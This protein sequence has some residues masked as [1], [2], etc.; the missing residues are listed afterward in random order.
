MKKIYS[1]ALNKKD[2]AWWFIPEL[3]CPIMLEL[4]KELNRRLIKNEGIYETDLSSSIQLLIDHQLNHFDSLKKKNRR[5]FK[6]TQKDTYDRKAEKFERDYGLL[7]AVDVRTILD[8]FVAYFTYVHPNWENVKGSHK[9]KYYKFKALSKSIANYRVPFA[10]A[11]IIIERLIDS[12]TLNS[13]EC[14]SIGSSHVSWG[15]VCESEIYE[16]MHELMRDELLPSTDVGKIKRSEEM[17]FD[18]ELRRVYKERFE[19]GIKILQDAGLIKKGGKASY[20]KRG[21]NVRHICLF[22]KI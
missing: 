3:Y 12:L 21:I 22:R 7:K 5:S 19:D 14:D 17:A 13:K 4:E 9:D 11:R 10:T 1:H 6:A 15:Y 20:K 18:L 2:S 16:A 8:H